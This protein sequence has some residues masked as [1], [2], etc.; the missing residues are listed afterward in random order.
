MK[1]HLLRLFIAAV[2]LLG[3]A[4]ACVRYFFFVSQTVYSESVAHLTEVFHQSNSVF[5]NLIYK[6][7]QSLHLWRDYL[8]DVKDDDQIDAFLAH[9]KEETGFTEFYF[10]S[11]DGGYRTTSGHYGYL[12]LKEKL[13]AII[14]EG[15]PCC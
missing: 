5:S 7:H 14:L 2:L 13:P 8:Q 12:D 11:R 10:I 9:A 4:G 1:K 15:K 3:I 6:N